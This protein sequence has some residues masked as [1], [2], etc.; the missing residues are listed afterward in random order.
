MLGAI[1]GVV[2]GALGGPVGAA[3]GGAV[4]DAL[5][6]GNG[7]NADAANAFEEILSSFGMQVVNEA[8]ADAQEF[9]S[10]DEEA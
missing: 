3:I 7:Q 1:A 6:G 9:M 8:F 10:D 2:G 5:G 4:G